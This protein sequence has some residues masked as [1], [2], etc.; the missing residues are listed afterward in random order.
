MASAL[1][2]L[3]A[4]VQE[5]LKLTEDDQPAIDFTVA[6]LIS[7]RISRELEP[8][9]GV[10]TGPP[11]SCKTELVRPFGDLPFSFM[12]DEMSSKALNS[13][14]QGGE[15]SLL[16]ELDDKVI[17]WP[18]FTTIITQDPKEAAAVMGGLRRCFDG[19]GYSRATGVGHKALKAQ[20]GLLACCTGRLDRFLVE[21]GTLG[22]RFVKCRVQRVRP[23]FEE[24]LRLASHVQEMAASKKDWRLALRI[25]AKSHLG[26][27]R[28]RQDKEVPPVV[29]EEYWNRLRHAVLLV[30]DSRALP[31]LRGAAYLEDTESPH[32]LQQQIVNLVWARTHLDGR[33]TWDEGDLLFALRVCMDTMPPESQRILRA[34]ASGEKVPTTD[35]VTASGSPGDRV[36][37]ILRQ[38]AHARLIIPASARAWSLTRDARTCWEVSGVETVAPPGEKE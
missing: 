7:A 35:I 38:F 33:D 21:H 10:L 17:L 12:L 4:A 5:I 31:Q 24:R 19:E 6:C 34:I 27:Y 16:P 36:T 28:I 2:S 8:A 14:F 15:F 13:G 3:R 11:G 23:A 9:W 32:R 18:D 25:A 26:K 37:D 20:F 29:P 30:A 1:E 22:D